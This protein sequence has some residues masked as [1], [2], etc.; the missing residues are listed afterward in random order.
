MFLLSVQEFGRSDCR[1]LL[2]RR[3]ALEIWDSV[4]VYTQVKPDGTLVV[5]VVVFH[6]DWEEPLQIACIRPR[7]HDRINGATLGR[8]L[9]RVV[10]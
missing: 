10:M 8:D 5:R 2:L 7:P 6:P 9:D 1:A 4:S 3:G